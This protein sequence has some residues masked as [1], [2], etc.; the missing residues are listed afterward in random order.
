M[1]FL[2]LKKGEPVLARFRDEH[3]KLTDQDFI[4]GASVTTHGAATIS[5]PA[6]HAIV[7]LYWN[8]DE[9]REPTFADCG[10]TAYIWNRR[11]KTFDVDSKQVP[12]LV[13]RECHRQFEHK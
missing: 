10:G 11:K 13:E 2:T 4:D 9:D 7:Q 1:T 12:G 6:E 3:G 5:L 8:S